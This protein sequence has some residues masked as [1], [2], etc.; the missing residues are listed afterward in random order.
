MKKDNAV[1]TVHS[2]HGRF[3]VDEDGFVVSRVDDSGELPNIWRFE[4]STWDGRA[5]DVDI[6]TVGY[7]LRDA[8][9]G[10]GE[11]ERPL[12]AEELA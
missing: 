6:L 1:F 3:R 4:G 10:R 12:T 11:Y 8:R 2:S 9:G 7:W 5:A